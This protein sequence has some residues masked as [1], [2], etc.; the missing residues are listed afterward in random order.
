MIRVRRHVVFALV[1]FGAGWQIT[2]LGRSVLLAS[3]S[4]LFLGLL[5]SFALFTSLFW[6]S[7]YLF[8]RRFFLAGLLFRLLPVRPVYYFV[9]IG[10]ERSKIAREM[11]STCREALVLLS[12][13]YTEDNIPPRVNFLNLPPRPLPPPPGGPP[14]AM[15][16]LVTE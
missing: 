10:V 14:G 8:L 12:I 6:F 7:N 3:D 5:L 1:I 4:S 11:L 13:E 16:D 9:S 2:W 15:L